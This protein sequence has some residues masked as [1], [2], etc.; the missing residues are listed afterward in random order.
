MYLGKVV[1]VAESKDMYRNPLHP[2]T[3][4]LLSAVPSTNPDIKRERI[5]LQ[6]DVPN[7]A[8]PPTG[9][10]F[11]TRCPHAQPRCSAEEPKLRE[12]AP[13][14]RVACHFFETLPVPTIIARAG[15]ANGKFA[16]RL[17][18][19]EAAKQ[20]RTVERVTR[21]FDVVPANAGTHNHRSVCCCRRHLTPCVS[22]I[23]RGVWVPAF[24]G[25]TDE[26]FRFQTT[27]AASLIS[28]RDS[29]EV[30]Y[31][32]P[33]SPIRGRGEAGRPMRP[34]AV[35]WQCYGVDAHTR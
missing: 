30:C 35:V 14:H 17:A 18:A 31:Q 20:T 27:D 25:T 8:N 7:P 12:A 11:H 22:P 29:P 9:C 16:E 34:I 15:A 5:V 6:G 26:G 19:F 23:G 32:F 28:R 1:E 33:P 13:G 4:A 21:S 2:Y 3:E 10:R 24:A